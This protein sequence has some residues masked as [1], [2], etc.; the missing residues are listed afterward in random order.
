MALGHLKPFNDFLPAPIFMV[1]LCCLQQSGIK[2]LHPDGETVYADSFKRVD[3]PPGEVI[4]ICFDRD[5]SYGEGLLGELERLRQLIDEY[6][7]CAPT[8][9]HGIEGIPRPLVHGDLFPQR[10]KVSSGQPFLKDDTVEGTV[11][12]KFLA[13]GHMHVEQPLCAVGGGQ[14][15][16]CRTRRELEVPEVLLARDVGYELFD[17]HRPGD[18]SSCLNVKAENRKN[19]AIEFPYSDLHSSWMTQPSAG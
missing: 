7:R 1:A 17:Q 12:A 4:R 13:E 19:Q 11:W 15:R 8:D 2:T 5:F 9:V 18:I 10:V 16:K 14:F 3:V 6:R